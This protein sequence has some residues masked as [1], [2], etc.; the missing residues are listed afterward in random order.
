VMRGQR[1]D[2]S[3]YR[4]D[5]VAGL[6]LVRGGTRSNENQS[7]HLQCGSRRAAGCV[8]GSHVRVGKHPV[9]S[10]SGGTALWTETQTVTVRGGLF[11]VLL[12]SA[13]SLS[14]E[15]FTGSTYL[16]V[17]VGADP[18]M[19]PRHQIVSVA[20]AI[21]AREATNADTLD[22]EDASAFALATHDHDS[23]YWNLIGNSG[24]ISGTHFLG[25]TDD[26][27]LEF[28][29]N[30]LRALRLQPGPDSPNLIGG[31]SDN[32]VTEGVWG[33]TIG[34]GG[35]VAPLNRVTDIFGTVGGGAGN[36]AGDGEG[37]VIGAACATVG[38]G[39]NNVASGENATI[40]GGNRNVASS[41]ESTAPSP[42]WAVDGATG[43][44]PTMPRLPAAAGQIRWMIPPATVSPTTTAR[45]EAEGTTR[46]GM[47]TGIRRTP[48]TRQ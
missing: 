37:G 23:R 36:Q 18:E 44:R 42:P 32:S 11:N 30:G 43:R 25:T 2:T 26:A 45:S 35:V 7:Y 22:G 38:G 12:G 39:V 21:H 47:T 34:G 16:G 27:A 19:T 29:V 20:Y 5:Q 14:A 48:S 1:E 28:R 8:P 6:G 13:E 33:A 24:T 10:A 46:R 41:T 4:A 40:G 9:G 3:R 31:Y 15:D 17:K